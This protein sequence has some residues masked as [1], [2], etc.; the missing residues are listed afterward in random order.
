MFF[1][2]SEIDLFVFN[3]CVFRHSMYKIY[4]YIIYISRIHFI[5]FFLNSYIGNDIFLFIFIISDSLLKI[6]TSDFHTDN[7]FIR[8]FF[9]CT[10]PHCKHVAIQIQR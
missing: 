2:W 7:I 4:R 8:F 10:I 3:V 9:S 6:R 1:D 5:D